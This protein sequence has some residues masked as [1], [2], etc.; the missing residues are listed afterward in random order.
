M[1]SK[2]NKL[3][4]KSKIWIEDERGKMVFGTGRLDLLEAVA[5]HGSLLAAAKKLHMSY[6]AAWGKIRATE[7]RLGQ[8]LLTRRVGGNKGGGSELTA[9]GKT[10]INRFRHLKSLCLKTSD[11]LFEDLFLGEFKDDFED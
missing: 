2:N 5:E 7:D 9:L 4:V 6:R 10:I 3:V 1:P 11:T 8:P